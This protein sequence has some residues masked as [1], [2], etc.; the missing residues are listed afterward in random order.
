MITITIPPD[1]LVSLE[2]VKVALGESGND[3]DD[4]IEALLMAAQS[5]LDGPNGWVGV[6]VA[7]QMVQTKASSFDCARLVGR[8]VV[9]ATVLYKDSEGE[10]VLDPA[11]YIVTS[12]GRLALTDGS[13][14]PTV[15]KQPDAITIA[16]EV[17]IDDPDDP[18]YQHMRTAIILHVRM[19]LDGHEP[20]VSRKAIESIVRPMWVPVA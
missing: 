9:A 17:G 1:P 20:E 10:H 11:S 13:S 4:L 14:W 3:R 16:Y 19:T 7:Q 12:D 18:R 5:E 8:P 15:L 6:C 2:E